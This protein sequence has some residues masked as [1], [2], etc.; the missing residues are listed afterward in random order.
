MRFVA[1]TVILSTL[2]FG[3]SADADDVVEPKSGVKFAARAGDMSLLGAGL[4]TKTF[5]KVKVYA[6][7]LY[8]ADAALAGPLAV[9]KGK[10][11]TPAFYRDLLNGDLGKQLVLTFPRDLSSG[12]IQ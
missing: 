6:I 2:G 5:L 11:D 12:Q 1:A 8:V 10:T 3:L 7:G 4:R 9:H